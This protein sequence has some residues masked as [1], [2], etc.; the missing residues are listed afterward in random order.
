MARQA[1]SW[2]LLWIGWSA[3]L[4][5]AQLAGSNIISTFAGSAWRF[6]GDGGPAVDAPI[7]S[8]PGLATD[9]QANVIFADFGNH[10][11]SRLNA[12]GT[13]TVLAGNGTEGFS[14]IM[15]RR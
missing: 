8:F 4:L 10:L 3:S 14:G 5:H 12:D 11:V 2:A 1:A 13:I 7:S 9:P 6:Q 15:A